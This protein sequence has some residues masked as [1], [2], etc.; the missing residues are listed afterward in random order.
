MPLKERPHFHPD[1]FDLS[2]RYS[3]SDPF[4]AG[5]DNH[6]SGNSRSNSFV[7]TVSYC[8]RPSNSS[9]WLAASA[10]FLRQTAQEREF[11]V[12]GCPSSA[13]VSYTH[14]TLPTNR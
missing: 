6:T 11:V 7:I 10:H 9:S 13:P 3:T 8:L 4:P 2:S 5:A 14:L 12:G 1:M